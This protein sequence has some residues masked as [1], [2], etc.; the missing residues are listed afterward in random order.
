MIINIL[1]LEMSRWV[2]ICGRLFEIILNAQINTEGFKPFR[3]AVLSMFMVLM[4]L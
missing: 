2:R 1:Y 3:D 4:K